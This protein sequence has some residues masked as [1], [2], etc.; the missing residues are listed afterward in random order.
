MSDHEKSLKA[1]LQ[2]YEDINA[3]KYDLAT[4]VKQMRKI[5]GMTQP[6]F[7]KLVKVAPRIII[8]IERGV[9]NPT[10]STLTKI[11]KPFGLSIIFHREE[12]T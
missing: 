7:A 6:E 11:G 5:V 1:R 12:Q 10:L 4:T 3:G 8:D 2:F 9:A